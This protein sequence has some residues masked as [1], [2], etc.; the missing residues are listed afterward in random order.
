MPRRPSGPSAASSTPAGVSGAMPIDLI[1]DE[2]WDTTL[3]VNL[4][5][6]VMICRR[7]I[8]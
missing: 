1:E 7:L 3:N 8:D 4:R 6:G 2:L 5:A